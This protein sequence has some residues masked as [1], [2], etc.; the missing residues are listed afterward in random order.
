MKKKKKNF[1]NI[2]NIIQIKI[3]EK[4]YNSEEIENVWKYLSVLLHEKY[5][6]KIKNIKKKKSEFLIKKQNNS[7]FFFNF[8]CFLLGIIKEKK[9]SSNFFIE[10]QSLFSL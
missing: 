2:H 3:F 8:Q 9:N 7:N 6:N 5:Q 1:A 4:V 10:F